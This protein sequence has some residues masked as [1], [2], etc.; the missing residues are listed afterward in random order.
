M[1]RVD[2]IAPRAAPTV[3]LEQRQTNPSGR[4]ARLKWT[5]VDDQRQP[6]I[7]RHAAVTNEQFFSDRHARAA[8][9]S[10][11]WAKNS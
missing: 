7:V 11:T 5:A 9:F 1:M 10:L 2:A 8:F 4:G 6:R 3:A